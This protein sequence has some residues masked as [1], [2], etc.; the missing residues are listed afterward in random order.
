MVEIGTRKIGTNDFHQ[1]RMLHNNCPNFVNDI[2]FHFLSI[3][4]SEILITYGYNDQTSLISKNFSVQT[5]TSGEKHRQHS[6]A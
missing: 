4:R 6:S 2:F 5:V 1:K 3:K